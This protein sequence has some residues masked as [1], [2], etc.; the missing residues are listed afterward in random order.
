MEKLN[1]DTFDP[2]KGITDNSS[3]GESGSGGSSGGDGD[4]SSEEN[5]KTPEESGSTM[6]DLE[7]IADNPGRWSFPYN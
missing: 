4:S 7:D 2:G 6:E 3:G 1:D 5:S